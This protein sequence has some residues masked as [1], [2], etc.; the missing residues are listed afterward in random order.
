M[1]SLDGVGQAWPRVPATAPALPV[2]RV[3]PLDPIA[4]IDVH[5]MVERATGFVGKSGKGDRAAAERLLQWMRAGSVDPIDVFRKVVAGTDASNPD[6]NARVL[7]VTYWLCIVGGPAVLAGG[8]HATHPRRPCALLRIVLDVL[9]ALGRDNAEDL[10]HDDAYVRAMHLTSPSSRNSSSSPPSSMS[11]R[12]RGR[13][14]IAATASAVEAYAISLGRKFIFHQRY[15]D[16]EANYSLDRFYRSLHVEN[17]ADDLRR[18]VNDERHSVIIS[19]AA[20][21]DVALIA[22]AATASV[23][24][25][26]YAQA[27]QDIVILAL[28]EATNALIFAEYLSLKLSSSG[29]SDYDLTR[30]KQWL[31]RKLREVVENGGNDVRMLKRFVDPNVYRSIT[32]PDAR[33]SRPESRHRREIVCHFTSFQGLHK[34]LSPPSALALPSR[35]RTYR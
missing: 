13:A 32:E 6:F 25:L 9:R 3:D 16:V 21:T 20:L 19:R 22:L 4:R 1:H 10:L 29:M 30:E 31:R 34:A 2:P 15:P 17:N 28:S 33:P 27:T 11:S 26:E 18:D 24:R 7:A 5:E 8:L 35:S 23:Q 14:A 12:P